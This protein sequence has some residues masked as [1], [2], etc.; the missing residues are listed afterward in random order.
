M[1]LALLAIF[2][3]LP[4]CAQ[5]LPGVPINPPG[6]SG[7]GN[8]AALPNNWFGAGGGY[9]PSGS[10]KGTGWASFA[11]LANRTSQVYS[12][13]TYD[14][15]PQ[16]GKIPT[17][18]V[19]TGAATV[20]REFGPVYIL[21]FMTVGATVSSTSTTGSLSGGGLVL[22]QSKKGWTVELGVRAVTGAVN[23]VFEGGF[24][25]TF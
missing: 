12:Y 23:R 5:D 24:G 18:S 7:V 14:I 3:A 8:T 11:V 10:P 6:T 2:L 21:G 13:S 4:V 15:I 17:T 9:N 19:R 25:R 16:K 20:L 22:Y 1:R